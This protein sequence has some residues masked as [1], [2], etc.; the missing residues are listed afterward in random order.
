MRCEWNPN[1]GVKAP[2]YECEFRKVGCHIDCLLYR[3]YRP[4][5]EKN[6]RARKLFRSQNYAILRSLAGTLYLYM[7]KEGE[8]NE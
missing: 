6:A 2:C 1:V 4:K 8:K 3:N 5:V 7:S